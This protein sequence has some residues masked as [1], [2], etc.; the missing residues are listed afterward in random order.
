MIEVELSRIII[1]EEEPEQAIVLKEKNGGKV[2][3]IVIGL[4][5]AVSIRM[6]VSGFKP[7]RPLTHDLMKSLIVT[8][9][10]NLD[11]VVIDKL[12]KGTFHAK[13]YFTTK[14]N[15]RKIVDARPS[16]SIAL[17][18]RTNSPIFVQNE[19]LERLDNDQ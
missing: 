6:E 8:L 11:K 12:V 13:L 1:N 15:Q 14:D 16:D 9:S 3:P 4:N 18:L 2:L 10:A 17:A 19:L 5:E 7:L